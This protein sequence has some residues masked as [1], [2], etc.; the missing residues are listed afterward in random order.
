VFDIDM[1][2]GSEVVG[3]VAKSCTIVESM[4]CADVLDS[5][6]PYCSRG[7]LGFFLGF[8]VSFDMMSPMERSA[9]PPACLSRGGVPSTA[10][11]KDERHATNS[12]ER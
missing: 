9:I 10:Y 1:T 3:A 7:F 12:V 8:D 6:V 4:C 5:M 11:P 2:P